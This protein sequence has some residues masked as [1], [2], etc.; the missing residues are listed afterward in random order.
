VGIGTLLGHAGDSNNPS[1]R[2]AFNL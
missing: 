1:M 2:S